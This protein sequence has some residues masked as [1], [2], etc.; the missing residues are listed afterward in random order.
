FIIGNIGFL[1]SGI[2]YNGFLPAL[3]PP[4][5]Q[6]WL[7]S[8]GYAWGYVG[9]GLLLAAHLA[10]ISFYDRLGL[11]DAGLAARLCLVSVGLWWGIFTIPAV[12]WLKDSPKTRRIQWRPALV[13]AIGQVMATLRTI[14]QRKPIFIFILA[15]FFYQDGIQTTILMASIYGA[16]ELH[17]S[18]AS[19]LGALLL[20]QAT[21]FPGALLFAKWAER[22]QTKRVLIGL[23][24]IWLGLILY[25][26]RMTAAWEFW[27]LAGL[28]GLVLGPS[29][30]LSRSYFSNLIPS[31][32][33]A[34][35]FGFF[36]VSGRFSAI[37]GPLVFGLTRDLTGSSRRAILSVLVFFL[38]GLALLVATPG[39]GQPGD[40]RE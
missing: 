23:L 38:I 3:A 19:L 33:S 29:Q 9:G 40:L 2:F 39:R 22:W 34:E 13:A 24:I 36:S 31:E 8:V 5:K 20:T 26:Y 27:T 11:S 7:S 17:L 18:M 4:N 28:I 14:R 30:S 6:D 1:G 25:A 32:Q 37:L 15:Y 16:T 10:V 35:F 21:A 12:L